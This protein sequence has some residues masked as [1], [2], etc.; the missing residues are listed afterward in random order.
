MSSSATDSRRRP[1]SC[2]ARRAR[3]RFATATRCPTDGTR[4]VKL[5]A[6]TDPFVGRELDGRYTVLEKLGQGGMGAVYRAQQHSVGREVAIKVVNANLVTDAE[7]IKRFLREA[8]LAS[9]L[10]HPNAVAVLDFGQTDDGVFYL[11][12]ELVGGRTLDAGDQGRGPVSPR[13]RRP[14]RHAGA[15]T[16]STARTRWRS[17]IAISSRRTSCCS[18]QGRDLVK[19]LDFGLAKSI[20]ARSDRRRR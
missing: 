2:T 17:S 1:A 12:M 16:R 13:A 20:V 6:R 10:A 14:H 7:V 11:V 9:K 18:S 5:K 19:V 4:L 15:A 8:K 3:R